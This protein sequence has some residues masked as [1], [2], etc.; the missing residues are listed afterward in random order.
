MPWKKPTL[1]PDCCSRNK[2][3]ATST[4]AISVCFIGKWYVQSW[5]LVLAY[6]WKSLLCEDV[7]SCYHFLLSD[8]EVGSGMLAWQEN[9][10]KWAGKILVQRLEMKDKKID[11]PLCGLQSHATLAQRIKQQA[12]EES[13]RGTLREIQRWVIIFG[14]KK[15]TEEWLQCIFY[16]VFMRNRSNWMS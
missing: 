16:C 9:A 13:G 12:F 10:S 3:A 8:S 4:V 1:R 6:C 2:H 7:L 11:T 5:K 15:V 14:H